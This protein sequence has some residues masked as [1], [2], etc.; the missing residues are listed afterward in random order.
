MKLGGRNYHLKGVFSSSINI[1]HVIY[2]KIHVR[3]PLFYPRDNHLNPLLL[4]I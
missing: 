2:T 3:K 1:V 4:I